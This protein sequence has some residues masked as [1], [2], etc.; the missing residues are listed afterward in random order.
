MRRRE[1]LPVWARPLLLG[2][3]CALALVLIRSQMP[4]VVLYR[5]ERSAGSITIAGLLLAV[6]LVGIWIGRRAS[7]R[8]RGT[9]AAHPREDV[10][11]GF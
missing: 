4:S 1:P 2:A 9:S 3:I 7:K 6:L 5:F 10:E 11:A 8:D